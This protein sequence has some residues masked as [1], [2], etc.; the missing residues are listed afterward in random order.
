MLASG[1]MLRKMRPENRL[2]GVLKLVVCR[3]Y[4]TAKSQ[5]KSAPPNNAKPPSRFAA[6]SSATRASKTTTYNAASDT[7]FPTAD[8]SQWPAT[9][10]RQSSKP[11]GSQGKRRPAAAKKAMM[12]GT[13]TA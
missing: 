12:N 7:R 11:A 8:Y 10:R 2:H 4:G 3:N 9:H 13:K 6:T 1:I 5:S